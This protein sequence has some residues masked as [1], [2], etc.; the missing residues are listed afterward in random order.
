MERN[1]CDEVKY[2]RIRLVVYMKSHFFIFLAGVLCF[3]SV[4]GKNFD[5][6]LVPDAETAIK[7]A[8]AI[9]ASY[10]GET[11]FRSNLELRGL[12]AIDE[13]DSWVV[14]HCQY[15]G[16]IFELKGDEVIMQRPIGMTIIISKKNGEVRELYYSH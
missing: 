1:R 13:G 6:L 9:M 15:T 4:Q 2:Q 11:K 7:I 5:R 8:S 14:C 3:G 16:K 10:D 12:K